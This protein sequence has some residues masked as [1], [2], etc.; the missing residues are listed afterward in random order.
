MQ[1]KVKGTK[2]SRAP[3]SSGIFEYT[4]SPPPGWGLESVSFVK[5][6]GDYELT[7]S[8]YHGLWKA[9]LT[10]ASI[11]VKE[12]SYQA[13]ANGAMDV[14]KKALTDTT[15]EEITRLCKMF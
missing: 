6:L 9:S 14:L 10:T 13:S 12:S 7:L 5:W 11:T 3:D 15:K 4:I 8:H 1:K 2:Q